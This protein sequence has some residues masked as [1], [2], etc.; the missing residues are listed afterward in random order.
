ML[1]KNNVFFHLWPGLTVEAIKK[2]VTNM[3]HMSAGRMDHVCKNI[4]STKLT[5]LLNSILH[6]LRSMQEPLPTTTNNNITQ[7]SNSNNLHDDNTQDYY[8]KIE[9]MQKIYMDQTGKFPIMSSNRSKYCFVSY[10]FDANAILVEPIK[11]R[12]AGE[13]VCAHNKIIQY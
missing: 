12:F 6:D 9:N 4:C 13:L 3:P 10:K 2:Y 5:Q 7:I 8:L 1:S 11:N